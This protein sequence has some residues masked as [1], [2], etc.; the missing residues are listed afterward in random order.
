MFFSMQGQDL[1]NFLQERSLTTWA[2]NK[3]P[4]DTL[5]GWTREPSWLDQDPKALMFATR[6]H[7]TSSN[8]YVQE[9]LKWFPLFW[10]WFQVEPV[11]VYKT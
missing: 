2:G 11:S 10:W 5:A 6:L 9:F 7:H 1:H 8:K 3:V 4:P